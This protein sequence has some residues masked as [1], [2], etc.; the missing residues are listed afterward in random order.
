MKAARAIK[1]A[2]REARA[3]KRI[4]HLNIVSLIDIFA[5]LVFYLL[6]NALV[7]EVLPS[8]KALTLPES[9]VQETPRQ[10]VVVIVTPDAILVDSKRV[11]DLALIQNLTGNVIP[12]LKFELQTKP[13]YQTDG[14]VASDT[15]R[16]EVN[17]MAD[18]ATPYA[19]LKKVMATCTEARFNKISLAVLQKKEGAP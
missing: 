18:K 14:A 1:R 19:L 10:K 13:L 15:N 16:G 4:V 12:D 6:V 9:S 5:I 8:S 2:Q 3:A 7:V 11:T 17:I